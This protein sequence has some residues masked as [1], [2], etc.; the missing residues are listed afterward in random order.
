MVELLATGYAS[1]LSISPVSDLRQL[2]FCL[3]SKSSE[4]LSETHV[5]AGSVWI[6]GWWCDRKTVWHVAAVKTLLESSIRQ[7]AALSSK[8][9]VQTT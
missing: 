7:A 5:V 3:L 6:D 2:L 9:V 4:G 1:W 8:C